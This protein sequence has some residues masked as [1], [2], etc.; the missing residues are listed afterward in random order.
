MAIRLLKKEEIA[1]L[2]NADK[3]REVAEG[4]K[5]SRR[6]DAL[7]ELS[8]KEELNLEK[9]RME[10]LKNIQEEISGFVAS[11]EALMSE[12]RV[13]RAEKERGLKDVD[14]K[15]GELDVLESDLEKRE[16]RFAASIVELEAQEKETAKNLKDS[17][18][19]LLRAHNKKEEAEKLRQAAFDDR[20]KANTTSVAA[21]LPSARVVA[22]EE[23]ISTFTPRLLSAGKES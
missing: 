16:V 12:V 18:D 3:A 2:Q 6:V 23:T 21:V 22:F 4:L 19:E 7:R 14:A 8:A 11:K 15:K 1:K 20:L 5:I 10:T 13:L 17:K 9:Y